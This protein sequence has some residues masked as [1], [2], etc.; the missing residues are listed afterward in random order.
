MARHLRD[1]R[2][3][4]PLVLQVE[5]LEHRRLLSGSLS[6]R[7]PPELAPQPAVELAAPPSKPGSSTHAPA[8]SMEEVAL[9][10]LL[11]AMGLPKAGFDAVHPAYER[12]E[13]AGAPPSGATDS[14]DR[15]PVS[16]TVAETA[17]RADL[18]PSG[19]GRWASAGGPGGDVPTGGAGPGLWTR[20]RDSVSPLG[21]GAD[22]AATPGPAQGTSS[23]HVPDQEAP[24]TVGLGGFGVPHRADVVAFGGTGE[25]GV[26]PGGR[27]ATA[28]PSPGVGDDG[29]GRDDGSDRSAIGA[30]LSHKV[31]VPNAH[32]YE[33]FTIGADAGGGRVSPGPVGLA[34]P[35]PPRGRGDGSVGPMR[36]GPW[37]DDGLALRPVRP[38]ITDRGLGPGAPAVAGAR[39][40]LP[41][42]ERVLSGAQAEGIAR[43]LLVPPEPE[44]LRP[45]HAGR[46]P[47]SPP[48]TP[49]PIQ[50][51]VLPP[52]SNP[53]GS[54]FLAM[55][56]L[57][58]TAQLGGPLVR[59]GDDRAPRS[60]DQSLDRPIL[61]MQDHLA[62]DRIGFGSRGIRGLE[63]P[64]PQPGDPS[65]QPAASP[66][67]PRCTYSI[68]AGDLGTEPEYTSGP[69]L[70]REFQDLLNRL[71]GIHGDAAGRLSSQ[72]VSEW[73][74]LMLVVAVAAGAARRELRQADDGL[75][76]A[77][78]RGIPMP[79]LVEGRP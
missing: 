62:N 57:P 25:A 14:L 61:V 2:R 15:D 37:V 5:F 30:D 38:D 64:V 4:M 27:V 45:A 67:R 53:S 36:A 59:G 12:L 1:H 26:P 54:R 66:A 77:D 41:G 42:L 78:D 24:G 8:G 56:L 17:E 76:R 3:P 31:G 75:P 34:S 50:F 20:Q 28:D 39:S 48:A 11:P 79:W 63:R 46:G 10:I 49:L 22:L 21:V 72:E 44:F 58:G 55:A 40:V 33:V 7:R 19:F 71:R 68:D 74:L 70:L 52:G 6:G 13:A 29:P 60:A 65:D 69:G 16:A 43:G 47:G 73:L 9:P 51:G 23:R 35:I 18:D 32:R